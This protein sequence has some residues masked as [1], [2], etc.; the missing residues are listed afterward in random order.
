MATFALQQIRYKRSVAGGVEPVVIGGPEWPSIIETASQSYPLGGLVYIDSNGTIA[1]C[2]NSSGLTSE[3]L[4]QAMKAATG[5]TGAAA[6]VRPIRTTDRFIA[7]LYHSTAATAVSAL[8]KINVMYNLILINGK[9]HV[10]V[11]NTT[12]E[13]GSTAK[14][15]VKVLGFEKEGFNSTGQWIEHTIGDIYAPAEIQFLSLSIGTDGDP[16]RRNLQWEG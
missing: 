8:A 9:W 12:V 14:A 11:E 16:R 7:N 6:Y 13:D 2:T 15:T 10:D 3:V 1:I 5:T 4:G